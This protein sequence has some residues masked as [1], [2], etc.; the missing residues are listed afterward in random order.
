MA[1]TTAAG[2][3][4]LQT[5]VLS[6]IPMKAAT[7]LPIAHKHVRLGIVAVEICNPT[8]KETK[9][10]YALHDTGS[11]MTLLQKLAVDEIGLSGN[12]YMQ[13]CRGMHVDADVLMEDAS[14]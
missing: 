12:P 14:V 13:P 9:S 5:N 3:H 8:T 4:T 2:N 7:P 11:Q 6:V 1:A 10:I